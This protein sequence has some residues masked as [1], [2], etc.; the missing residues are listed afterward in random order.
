VAKK[1]EKLTDEFDAESEDGQRFHVLVY[2]T[3]IDTRTMR[4]ATSPP[5]E[6][7]KE[8]LTTEGYHCNYIDDNTFEIVQLGLQVKRV[9]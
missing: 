1:W 3:M 6:G 9:K 8:A 7:M 4:D 5:C 2:T